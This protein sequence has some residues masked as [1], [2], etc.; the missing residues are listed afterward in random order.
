MCRAL[1][2][3]RASFYRW[4]TPAEP[5]PRAVR[6][7][8]LVTAVTELYTKEAGRAGRDQLTLLLNAAGTKV[9]SPTVGAIM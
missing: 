8:E 4:R 2:I 9:S 1:R 7:E 3:S 6:H 5:S